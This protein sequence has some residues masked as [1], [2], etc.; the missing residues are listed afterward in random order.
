MLIDGKIRTMVVD[1]RTMV[2][3]SLAI[4]LECMAGVRI[5]AQAAN[6]AE[7]LAAL[8]HVELNVILFALTH[9]HA[10]GTLAGLL[11]TAYGRSLIVLVTVDSPGLSLIAKQ[12]GA[13]TIL[14][15]DLPLEALIAAIENVHTSM[16][17]TRTETIE[18]APERA[19]LMTAR[20]QTLP[21]FQPHAMP[22]NQT[23]SADNAAEAASRIARL[24]RRE[25]E[26]IGA[27]GAGLTSAEIIEHLAITTSTL[28]HHLTSIF[29]KIEVSNRVELT[30][31]AYHN[32]MINL[33]QVPG[34]NNPVHT[35]K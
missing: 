7:A 23:S 16:Q 29:K 2:R 27:V 20:T 9:E 15:E 26:V 25:R 5:Y 10:L 19:P 1:R 17:L 13:S 32:N 11:N 30:V 33:R 14:C 31:F 3:S 4:A 22:L 34:S 18:R 28:R 24:T 8:R 21:E 6:L 35:A 12:Y